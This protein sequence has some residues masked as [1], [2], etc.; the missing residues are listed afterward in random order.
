MTTR[1][2]E[3]KDAPKLNLNIG[4]EAHRTLKVLAASDELS[5]TQVT[6]SAIMSFSE[7]LPDEREDLYAKFLNL[8]DVE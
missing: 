1:R 8:G 5:M 3:R 6:V 4:P 7:L 2:R